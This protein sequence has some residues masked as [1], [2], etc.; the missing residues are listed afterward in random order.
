LVTE[1]EYRGS[2]LV[3]SIAR[4]L[5]RRK[6]LGRLTLGAFGI[7]M[8]LL[9]LSKEAEAVTYKCCQLCYS[10]SGSCSGCTCTWCWW[11]YHPPSQGQY[12]CCE[13]YWSG[14]FCN[15]SCNHV[16]CS[17]ANGPFA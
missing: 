3:S 5:E 13:C 4:P 1:T 16:Y 7:A 17:Y 8:G 12:Q 2:D 15:G 6:A 9:G 11:C 10:P 14:T